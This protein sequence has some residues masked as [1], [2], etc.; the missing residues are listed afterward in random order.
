LDECSR[1]GDLRIA[2]ECIEIMEECAVCGT[3]VVPEFLEHGID[4]DG[5]ALER[6]GSVSGASPRTGAC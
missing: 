4:L 5:L 6:M 3:R 2:N 1:D